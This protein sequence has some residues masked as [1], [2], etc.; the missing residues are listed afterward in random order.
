MSRTTQIRLALAALA[1]GALLL[2]ACGRQASPSTGAADV[3][4]TGVASGF[5][6]AKVERVVDGDTAIFRLSSGARERVRFIGVDTPESTTTHE[7]FGEEASAYTKRVLTPGRSVLLELD[8]EQRDRYERLLAYVWLETPATLGDAEIRAKMLNA[9]LAIDG[10]A[11]QMTIAPNVKYADSF[12]RYV[13]EARDAQRGLWA[14]D[15]G[16]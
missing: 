10:Y 8:A 6:L 15:V 5:V 7:P 2:G 9:Q 4:A 1:A 13:A 11:Q 14:P 3:T 16:Q 12:R